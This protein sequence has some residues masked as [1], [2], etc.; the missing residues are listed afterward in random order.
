[1]DTKANTGQFNAPSISPDGSLIA[2]GMVVPSPND[3]QTHHRLQFS[4]G[5]YSRAERKWKTY[6]NFDDIGASA[7]S[8]D[9]SK[10]A[11][12]A[13]EGGKQQLRIF[14]RHTETI[15]VWDKA[16][17]KWSAGGKGSLGWS[18]AGDRLAVEVQDAGKSVIGV[19]DLGTGNLQPIAEGYEPAW[20]PLGDWIAYYSGQKCMLVHP[21]GTVKKV[22]SDVGGRAFGY[23]SLAW[24]L[25]WSPDGKQLLA[26]KIKGDGPHLDV[27]LIDI[28]N[29][30]AVTKAQNSLPVF[31]WARQRK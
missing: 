28:A 21:D 8:P 22:V 9:G 24:G 25:V 30:Q 6:G 29:G 2:W 26:N 18:P 12:V 19:L 4:F 16:S 11:F 15:T 20:S 7:F 23:R 14:D 1:L 3:Q 13:A 31:G 5:I 27:V 10:V 17:I